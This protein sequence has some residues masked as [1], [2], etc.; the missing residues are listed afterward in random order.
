MAQVRS[1]EVAHCFVQLGGIPQRQGNQEPLQG[2]LLADVDPADGPEVDEAEV[3]GAQ[4]KHVPRMGIGMERPLNEDL[5]EQGVQEH[6]AQSLAVD[7]EPLDLGSGVTQADTVETLHDERAVARE[8][9]VHRRNADSVMRTSRCGDSRDV[10]GLDAEVELLA[11]RVGEPTSEVG[12]VETAR[13]VRP[14]FEAVAEP[15]D[16]V[17]VPDDRFDDAWPLDLEHDGRTVEERRPVHLGERRAGDRLR[18]DLL[19]DL[20]WVLAELRLQNSPHLAPGGGRHAVL[21]LRQLR[22]HGFGQEVASGGEHLAELDE[23]RTGLLERSPEAPPQLHGVGPRTASD[24]PEPVS[25]HNPR[26]LR[27]ATNATCG[28]SKSSQRVSCPAACISPCWPGEQLRQH[29]EQHR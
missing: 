10:A 18:V 5:A 2:S 3:A 12:D 25:C 17:E 9:G 29:H 4:Q 26:E 15:A 11:E 6:P 21:E 13:P 1:C 20:R 27:V 14:R 23:E 8:V 7:A 19:E 22:R 28:P 16:H 24:P